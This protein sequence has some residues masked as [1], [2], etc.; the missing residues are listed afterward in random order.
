MGGTPACPG[1]GAHP[2]ARVQAAPACEVGE[3]LVSTYLEALLAVATAARQLVK[4]AG[5][6]DITCGC[7]EIVRDA[8]LVALESALEAAGYGLS[9]EDLEAALQREGGK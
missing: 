5:D 7:H 9:D 4:H 3:G 2:A 8:D 1:E 6:V